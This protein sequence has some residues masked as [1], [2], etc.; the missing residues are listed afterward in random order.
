MKTR[1][2]TS[3]EAKNI[4]AELE[5]KTKLTPNIICRYGI[6]LSLKS[7][8]KLKFNYDSNGQ[9]F[10]R[11]IL[12]GDYDIVFRELIKQQE[13][14]HIED[15]EY[16]VKYLKAHL[17]NGVRLL[18]NEIEICGSFDNFINEYFNP[19]RGGTI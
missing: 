18:K 17:E 6:I 14:R 7:N 1:V 19:E 13:N 11:P 9:E 15:D 3:L 8:N 16:F 10:H 4:L 5:I 2:Y 12:T